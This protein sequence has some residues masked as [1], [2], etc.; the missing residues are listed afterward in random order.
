M[1]RCGPA[2]VK[3]IKDGEVYHRYDTGFIFAEV[4]GDR[5]HWEISEDGSIKPISIDTKAI[6]KSIST[7]L[8]GRYSRSDITSD[9]KHEEGRKLHGYCTFCRKI[10]K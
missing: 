1:L 8:P 4:N 5:V 3:A 7:K 9:Y 2:S 10:G 6:G